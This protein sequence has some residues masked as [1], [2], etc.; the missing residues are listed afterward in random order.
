MLKFSSALQ[1]LQPFLPEPLTT[2]AHALALF[3][4]GSGLTW[5]VC[6]SSADLYCTLEVDSFGY[7]VSKA[8]TRVFRDTTEP[9]WDE[10][11]RGGSCVSQFVTEHAS[12]LGVTSLTRPAASP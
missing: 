6:P 9:K 2:T 1:S 5:Y 12:L 8:K 4:A 10:V 3:L 7:F 11:S